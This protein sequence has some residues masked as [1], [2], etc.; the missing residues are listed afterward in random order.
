[1]LLPLTVPNFH[2]NMTAF[3]IDD[4]P[5]ARKTLQDTLARHCPD[6][7]VLGEANSVR[8]GV[9]LLQHA[10]PDVLFLDVQL[11]DGSGFDVLDQFP[12][13]AFQVVFITAHDSFAVRAFRYYAANYLLKPVVAS[14]LV[15]AVAHIRASQYQND[16]LLQMLK[17]SF[18]IQRLDKIVI[19]TA[20]EVAILRLSDIIRLEGEGNY[21]TFVM[22]DGEKVI[23]SKGIK[24]FEDLLPLETFYRVHQSHLLQVRHVRKYLKEDGGYAL[25]R[26]GDKIPVARRKKDGFLEILTKF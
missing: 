4:E 9:A 18:N 13:A 11:R 3:I 16:T 8:E 22:V 26:N 1:M 5:D 12:R 15:D 21:T 10:A 14:E 25:M 19:S 17:G 2:P 7:Q 6:V 23:A 24:E 20:E